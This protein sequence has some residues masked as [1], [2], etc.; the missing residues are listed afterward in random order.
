M[1]QV[2][3]EVPTE[4]VYIDS[5]GLK[6]MSEHK[7]QQQLEGDY[8]HIDNVNENKLYYFRCGEVINRIGKVYNKYAGMP[9]NQEAWVGIWGD[10]SYNSLQEIIGDVINNREKVYE[11]K[12][13]NDFTK[14]YQEGKI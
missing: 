1:K 13:F 5:E 2:V 3:L 9:I 12:T 6:F 8:V 7:P 10:E 11:F 14:A 4:E